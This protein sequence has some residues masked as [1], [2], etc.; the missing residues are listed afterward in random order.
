M[1]TIMTNLYNDIKFKESKTDSQ[2][3]IY[4]RVEVLWRAC[5]LEKLDCIREAFLQYQNWKSSAD[6]DQINP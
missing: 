6:P 2:L 1:L 5:T 3:T 4:N